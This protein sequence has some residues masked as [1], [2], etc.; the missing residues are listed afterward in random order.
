M[1]IDVGPQHRDPLD[2]ATLDSTELRSLGTQPPTTRHTCPLETHC[3]PSRGTIVLLEGGIA[4][5][6]R[7]KRGNDKDQ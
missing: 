4:A 1:I 7:D 2:A 6:G 3:T 5:W